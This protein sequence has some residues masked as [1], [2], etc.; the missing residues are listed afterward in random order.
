MINTIKFSQF[1]NGGNLNNADTTVGLYAGANTYF[2]NP[3]TF[4]APGDTASRPAPGPTVNYM[5]RFNTDTQIYEYYNAILMAWL[6]LIPP[7]GIEVW[8]NVTTPAVTIQNNNGYVTNY[9]AS[10]VT[11]TLPAF[12]SFGSIVEIVGTS[13]DGWS[14]IYG[15]GQNIIFGN[16]QT[17]VTTGS[18]TATNRY[19]SVKL[20]CTIANTTW[21]IIS[22]IGNP[23]WV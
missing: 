9:G 11:Y 12:S 23:Q 22:V 6:Q 4:L 10:I 15:G 21:Q 19:D 7:T 1:A 8:N 2:A 20:L 16:Q 3:W 13:G 17:T 18:L 14:I 5:L